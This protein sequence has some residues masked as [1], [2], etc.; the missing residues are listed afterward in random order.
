MDGK[1]F[2]PELQA[3]PSMRRLTRTSLG[4]SKQTRWMLTACPS[5]HPREVP[6]AQEDLVPGAVGA[7]VLR[8]VVRRQPIRTDLH[9]LIRVSLVLLSDMVEETAE[10]QVEK[11][12][13]PRQF[14]LS[15]ILEETDPRV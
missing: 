10:E 4:I 9:S 2:P 13:E 8:L 7:R 3:D 11:T 12:I 1:L 6:E 14:K 5:V 15:E